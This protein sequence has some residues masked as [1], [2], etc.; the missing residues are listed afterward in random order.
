MR[1]PNCIYFCLSHKY[2]W[3]DNHLYAHLTDTILSCLFFSLDIFRHGVVGYVLPKPVLYNILLNRVPADK[4]FYGVKVLSVSSGD[5]FVTV[6]KDNGDTLVC[7]IVVGA[8]GTY[9]AVRQSIF[10]HMRKDKVM[11][12][13][14]KEPMKYSTVCLIGQT[15]PLSDVE[16]PIMAQQDSQFIRVF[17]KSKPYSVL[18]HSLQKK[19]KKEGWAL[20]LLL[21]FLYF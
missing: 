3:N 17:G 7:D 6:L 1:R 16:F 11:D 5:S 13:K 9:S 8:D 14:D 20:A 19:K 4:I 15:R 2:A 10:D 12:P 18:V 21:M